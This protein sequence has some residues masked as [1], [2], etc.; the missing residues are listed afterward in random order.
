MQSSEVLESLTNIKKPL[1]CDLRCCLSDGID[2]YF[3]AFRVGRLAHSDQSDPVLIT[4]FSNFGEARF[5]L[6]ALGQ[7]PN[8]MAKM[9][10]AC[11]SER[12]V[13]RLHCT[14]GLRLKLKA[15]HIDLTAWQQFKTHRGD[16]DV[17]WSRPLSSLWAT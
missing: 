16:K 3:A 12:F 10:V 6:G 1:D 13:R 11:L 15:V 4:V 8:E 14:A 17:V 2:K 5:R 7:V 9:S